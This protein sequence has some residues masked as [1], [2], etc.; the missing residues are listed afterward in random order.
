MTDFKS[1]V[2]PQKSGHQMKTIVEKQVVERRQRPLTC[3][4]H[5]LNLNQVSS[6]K[7]V[8]TLTLLNSSGMSLR[9]YWCAQS[10][11]RLVI[12]TRTYNNH[13][14][15]PRAASVHTSSFQFGVNCIFEVY[16]TYRRLQWIM[17]QDW[18]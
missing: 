10:Y 15:K 13:S 2:N 7:F 1:L 6:L 16:T 18:T 12:R 11:E 9:V 3:T 8:L 17:D 14:L 4:H 5:T